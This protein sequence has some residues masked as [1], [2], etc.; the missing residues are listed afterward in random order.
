ME[1]GGMSPVSREQGSQDNLKDAATLGEYIELNKKLEIAL[2]ELS[3]QLREELSVGDAH[4]V[5]GRRTYEMIF[6]DKDKSIASVNF[7][8]EKID[9]FKNIDDI[10]ERLKKMSE[11]LKKLGFNKNAPSGEKLYSEVVENRRRKS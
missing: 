1:V 6:V 3:P 4:V 7:R 9:S 11:E 8:T 10:T 2:E 5:H